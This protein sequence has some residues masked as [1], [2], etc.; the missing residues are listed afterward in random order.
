MADL[1]THTL[2]EEESIADLVPWPAGYGHT[3]A[4]EVRFTLFGERVLWRT[5]PWPEGYGHV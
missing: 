2:F 4:L 5:V 3:P 1:N